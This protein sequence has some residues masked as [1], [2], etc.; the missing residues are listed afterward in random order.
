[1]KVTLKNL[2]VEPGAPVKSF[3]GM[4]VY[5]NYCQNQ[6]PLLH[7]GKV[8]FFLN[9]SDWDKLR[10]DEFIFNWLKSNA[11]IFREEHSNFFSLKITMYESEFD[12]FS[13]MISEQHEYI[14]RS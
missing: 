4:F 10:K 1:M 11:G 9:R 3:L 12:E 6:E 5:N 14:G 13:E 8:S 2:E 7:E